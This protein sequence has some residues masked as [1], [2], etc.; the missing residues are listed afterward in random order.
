[1]TR[2]KI[3]HLIA[4]GTITMRHNANLDGALVP[5]SETFDT[6][7]VMEELGK[8]YDIKS[9]FITDIDSTNMNIDYWS[10]IISVIESHY[11]KFD[12]FVITHGTDTMSYTASALSFAI[13]DLG[14]PIVLTGS[15]L[16]I[17]EQRTDGWQNLISAFEVAAMDIGE[18]V[19]VFGHNIVR[20]NRSTKISESDF[21]AFV[22]N[23]YP[24]LGKISSTIKLENFH[25]PR[26]RRKPKFSPSFS[27][28][29][30]VYTLIPGTDYTYF[31]HLLKYDLRGII[32]TAVG[33]GNI[34]TIDKDF[35][36]LIKEATDRNIA[37]I[38]ST[39]CTHGSV[40]TS[41][42]ETGLAA[43]KSGAI[44]ADIM[45]IEAASMKLMWTLG[46]SENLKDIYSL[47]QENLA[48]EF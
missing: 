41:A 46:Q 34:P 25:R 14:K 38:I 8:T 28:K 47:M 42:Y 4:G 16:P 23:K 3:L 2:A 6:T 15:Q 36:S 29:V 48:G 1:M 18:V 35:G 44:T 22:S 19:I 32:I 37:V 27:N 45:T 13:Q 20:G 17:T 33:A 21:N 39:Q 26:H 5:A 43:Q 12:G 7:G 11:S 9:I 24:L 40:N 10:K 30:F 31:E